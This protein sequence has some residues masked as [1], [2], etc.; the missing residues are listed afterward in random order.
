MGAG[1]LRH[2]HEQLS[3]MD[4]DPLTETVDAAST[5]AVKTRNATIIR[6]RVAYANMTGTYIFL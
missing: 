5:G 6:R 2:T 3:N 4:D 1:T